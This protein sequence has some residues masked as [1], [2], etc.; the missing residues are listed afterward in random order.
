MKFLIVFVALF[1]LAVAAPAQSD[2]V[3]VL[4]QDSNVGI[5]NF[6]T[7]PDGYTL[8]LETSD[9]TK[10]S[11]EAILNNIGTEDEAIS[12]KGTYSY[13]GDD[14][15]TYQVNFVADQNGYQPEGAHI[16]KV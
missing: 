4:R 2:D 7:R 14:G 13:V 6:Q 9:G 11:E 12:V 16:P 8:Q 3:Q 15:V 1:A 5:D 10:R